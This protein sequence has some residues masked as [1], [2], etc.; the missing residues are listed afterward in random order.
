MWRTVLQVA[1]FFYGQIFSV[2]LKKKKKT[3]RTRRRVMQ[4]LQVRVLLLLIVIVSAAVESFAPAAPRRC[5]VFL[6]EKASARSSR[7]EEEGG[8]D[9]NRLSDLDARVLQ[10]MLRDDKLD[11]S[12]EQNMKKLLERGVAPK[13][14]PSFE[15]EERKEEEADGPYASRVLKVGRKSRP[16]GF[17]FV[18]PAG[19]A[20]FPWL[21]LIDD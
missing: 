1:R 9:D 4:S 21:W 7:Q 10:T 19:E 14:A 18:Q 6:R 20:R 17:G 5:Q 13:E 15:K 8:D 12:T 3:E 11:L 16:L 2:P